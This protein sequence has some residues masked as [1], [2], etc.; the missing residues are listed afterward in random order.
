MNQ[1]AS[2]IPTISTS[3]DPGIR[4]RAQAALEA[5]HDEALADVQVCGQ[6]RFVE[7][8]AQA[9]AFRAK[10]CELETQAH[11]Q[12]LSWSEE[13]MKLERRI[14]SGELEHKALEHNLLKEISRLE[15]A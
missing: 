7:L 12:R 2:V 13:R 14:N 10:I 6:E 5:R 4:R 11:H 1:A 3:E 15:E 8:E 9:S